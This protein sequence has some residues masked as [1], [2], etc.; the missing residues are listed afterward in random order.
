MAPA[1]AGIDFAHLKILVWNSGMVFE[2]TTGS[3][4]VYEFFFW[5]HSRMKKCM[6]IGNGL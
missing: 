4:V 1:S 6:N 2:G 3:E 5:L